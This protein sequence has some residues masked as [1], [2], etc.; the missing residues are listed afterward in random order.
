MRNYSL[1][2]MNISGVQNVDIE[3]DITYLLLIFINITG[4][5]PYDVFFCPII[6]ADMWL[7]TG[8]ESLLLYFRL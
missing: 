5:V 4:I 3:G 7:N 2:S 8:F 1:G 6:E